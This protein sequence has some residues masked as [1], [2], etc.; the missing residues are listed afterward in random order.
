MVDDEDFE[1]LARY[2]WHAEKGTRT[3]YAVRSKRVN[4]DPKTM[5]HRQILGISG[6]YVLTD[7]I[8]GLNNQRDNLRVSTFLNNNRNRKPWPNSTSRFVGVCWLKADKIWRASIQIDGVPKSLGRF[9]SEVDAAR[10]RDAAAKKYYGE[11]A[12]LNL[13]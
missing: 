3:F 11:V 10:A 2:K 9:K 6:R 12:Y 1:E 8:D 7:H 5:M 4:G 13:P